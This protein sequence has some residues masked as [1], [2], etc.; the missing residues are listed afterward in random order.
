M[1]PFI[2]RDERTHGQTD[3]GH[4]IISRP[5][6]INRREIISQKAGP[7]SIYTTHCIR[8]T[9]STVL[10]HMLAHTNVDHNDI[11]SATGNKHPKIVLPYIKTCSNAKRREMSILSSY[12]KDRDSENQPRSTQASV[13]ISDSKVMEQSLFCENWKQIGL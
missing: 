8:A 6:P 7:S 2:K 3:I 5:G 1:K 4:F 9:I 10:A 11:I 13:D 12:G